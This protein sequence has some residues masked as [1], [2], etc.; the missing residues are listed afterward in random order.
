MFFYTQLDISVAI[1]FSNS[2]VCFCFLFKAKIPVLLTVMFGVVIII[3]S[4]KFRGA[5]RR[6]QGTTS[7]L[8]KGE[9]GKLLDPKLF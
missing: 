1:M 9:H 8:S 5:Q 4:D 6:V 7:R 3:Y 2:V